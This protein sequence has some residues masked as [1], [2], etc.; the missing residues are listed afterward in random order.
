M[1][2]YKP[3]INNRWVLVEFTDFE[4]AQDF[5][6]EN[7]LPLDKATRLTCLDNREVELVLLRNLAHQVTR[8]KSDKRR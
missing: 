4:A 8:C 2:D 1:K 3:F 5:M 7:D 6:C